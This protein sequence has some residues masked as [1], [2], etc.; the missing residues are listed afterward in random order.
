MTADDILITIVV[1]LS[2]FLVTLLVLIGLWYVWR[3]MIRLRT[4]VHAIQEANERAPVDTRV[5]V[6]V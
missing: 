3:Q 1:C 5:F 2:C 6:S 4:V